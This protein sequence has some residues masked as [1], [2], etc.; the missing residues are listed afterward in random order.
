MTNP[1]GASSKATSRTAKR[2][3]FVHGSVSIN[4][5]AAFVFGIIFISVML[6]FAVLFPNPSPSTQK[7]F[8]T[9]LALA[10]GGVG[11][12]LPGE[13]RLRSVP[14]LRAGGALGLFALVYLFQPQIVKSVGNF[15]APDD[16]GRGDIDAIVAAADKGD[17]ASAVATLGPGLKYFGISEKD[18]EEMIANTRRPLGKVEDRKLVSAGMV[19][20]PAGWPA[21][22]YKVASFRTKFAASPQCRPEMV[23]LRG[24]DK[25][26]WEGWSYQ[27]GFTDIPCA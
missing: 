7:T 9:V 2:Q 6:V 14:F 3:G 1:V 22:I 13:L 5:A 10:A 24:N 11:A 27:I 26:Q 21:G 20:S 12:M 4:V 18:A 17:G 15:K 25:Q 23:A 8:S 19:E 16:S